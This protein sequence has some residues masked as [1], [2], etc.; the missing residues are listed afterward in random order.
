MH[1]TNDIRLETGVINDVVV[2]SPPLNSIVGHCT[3]LPRMPSA[4]ILIEHHY[5]P[6]VLRL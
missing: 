6:S 4:G 2:Q 5:G 3:L 1:I